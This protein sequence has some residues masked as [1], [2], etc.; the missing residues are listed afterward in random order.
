[1]LTNDVLADKSQI[2]M[3]QKNKS[4]AGQERRKKLSER[5]ISNCKS[6]LRQLL[7]HAYA[8]PSVLYAHILYAKTKRRLLLI[9][10]GSRVYMTDASAR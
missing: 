1:M 10:R 7:R 5:T 6:G 3:R 4:L 2:G 8:L 9:G